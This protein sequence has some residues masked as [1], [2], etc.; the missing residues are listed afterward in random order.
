[1]TA[2]G[3][4]TYAKYKDCDPYKSG[5]MTKFDQVSSPMNPMYLAKQNK[6]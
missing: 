4:V 3:L 1:M 2:V 5:K 6:L